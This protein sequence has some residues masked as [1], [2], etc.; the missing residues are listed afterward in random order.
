MDIEQCREACRQFDCAAVNLFQIG[1]FAFKCEILNS[2]YGM[3][4]ATGA[5]CYYASDAMG[6]YGY[7][8]YGGYGGYFGRRK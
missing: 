2:I 7:G 6:A 4:P 5:A 3:Q 1:E 8:G